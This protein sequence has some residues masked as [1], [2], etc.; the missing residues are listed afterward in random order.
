MDD[1]DFVL[2]RVMRSIERFWYSAQNGRGDGGM[3]EVECR[4]LAPESS[5]AEE[6]G[7]AD[8]LLSSA[9]SFNMNRRGTEPYDLYGGRSG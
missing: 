5:P 2:G 3:P 4:S 9:H 7:I 6:S 1:T 8:G